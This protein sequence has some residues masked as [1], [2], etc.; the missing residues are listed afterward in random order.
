[1]SEHSIHNQSLKSASLSDHTANGGLRRLFRMDFPELACRSRQEAFKWA[2]RLGSAA[3]IRRVPKRVTLDK[4]SRRHSESFDRFLSNANACFF[5]GV[6]DE[7][8]PAALAIGASQHLSDVVATADKLCRAR[9]DLLGYSNL[10]FG[11]PPDWQLDPI[12]GR[13]APFVHWTRL[14]PLDSSSLGD[15]K[16]IWELNRHQWLV[17]LAQA[18]RLTREERYAEALIEYLQ[19]W[20]EANPPGMG[21]NWTSSLEV[22]FRLISWCWVLLL[23]RES[24]ALTLSVFAKLVKSVRSHATHIERYLSYYFSPNTH[25]TGEALGLLYAGV[26][27]PE[28]KRAE[29][30]RS[31]ATRILIQEIERQVL[32]DGVYFERST[33]Y[34]RYTADIYFHFLIL[35]SR[36]GIEVPIVVKER[37]RSM[38][39]FLVAIR[40]PDGSVPSI[41]DADG[42]Y[43]LPLSRSDPADFRTMFSTAAVL[44]NEP[45]YAWAAEKLASDTL[46]L[47]GTSAVDAFEGL[48]MS[49]PP[50]DVCRMFSA[51]GF[52]VMRS[53]WEANCHSLIFDTGPLCSHLSSGHGHAGLLSIQCSAFGQP[54]VVDAGTHCYTADSETRDFF[55]GTAAHSTV[56]VDGKSQAEFA[57]PF[58]WQSRC[59]ARLRRW[60]SNDTLAFADAEHDGYR[61]LPDPVTH[62][63]RVIFVK[64][65]Y[66]IVVDDL[67]GTSTH[68]IDIRFQF[69]PMHVQIDGMGW[70]SAT[71]AGRR[72]LLVHSFT[73]AS[74]AAEVREG[75]CD[76]LEG[77][78]SPNY[79]QL[80]QAP[81]LT[82]TTTAALPLRVVTL[83]WPIESVDEE[84]PRVEIIPQ[85]GGVPI[86]LMF[87][88][89]GET[90]LF[91]DGE[92][93]V[94]RSI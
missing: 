45:V 82:Y 67:T 46:W 6:F 79:G 15:S 76:P 88:D 7:R 26:L 54:I 53:G 50:T 56:M 9:F 4:S 73:S 2:E 36:A 55:R 40:Q 12:S 19:D 3:D 65:R 77:W 5:E 33:S 31:L 64:P 92:P 72:G 68:R 11:D 74:I 48:V 16:V 93:L 29:R 21:I 62:R 66:W 1:M 10:D 20:H 42:G 32:S 71:R 34:Q 59:A 23:I 60:A 70:V 51:G 44:F 13:A 22:S 43:V 27:F 52:A 58:S 75:R 83:L 14:D 18:Y 24:R 38:L 17:T 57:G 90:V 28:I 84:R 39:D 89:F 78:V 37:L 86:G 35:G 25:L 85:C 63:R 91:E 80:E 87:P 47:L 49:P 94:Q 81:V 69:A 41:G 61:T 8:V 30:W